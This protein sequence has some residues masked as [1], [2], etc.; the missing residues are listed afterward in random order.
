[1]SSP[2]LNAR[3]IDLGSRVAGLGLFLP[4]LVARVERLEQDRQGTYE[5]LHKLTRKVEEQAALLE[6]LQN[7]NK[8]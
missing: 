3:I 8:G 6:S 4:E 7:A 1:M 2:E 5:M